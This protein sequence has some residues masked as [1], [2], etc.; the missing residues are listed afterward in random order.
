MTDKHISALRL[1]KV[2][3]RAVLLAIV[4]LAYHDYATYEPPPVREVNV[5]HIVGAYR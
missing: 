4:L 2:V 3:L 1:A 5:V